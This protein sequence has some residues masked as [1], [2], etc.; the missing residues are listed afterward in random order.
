MRLQ[1]GLLRLWIVGAALWIG[2][3]A[4]ALSGHVRAPPFDPTK[5][6]EIVSAPSLP[7]RV[8]VGIEVALIPPALAFAVGAALVWAVKGFSSP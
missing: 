7:D 8:T 2:G 6:Y 4:F 1:R 3:V 5:P